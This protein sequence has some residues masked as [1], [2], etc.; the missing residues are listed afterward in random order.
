AAS[1][2]PRR[3]RTE[4]A[5]WRTARS[6]SAA[7]ESGVWG[8]SGARASAGKYRSRSSRRRT[9]R[10]VLTA[11][12]S[13]GF[14][15]Q[16][17]LLGGVQDDRLALLEDDLLGD[18]HLASGLLGR[19]VVHH[20]QHRGLEDGAETAGAGLAPDGLGGDGLQRAVGELQRHT[21][22]VE[23]LPVLLH[24][25]V[26]RLAED[27]HQRTLV[28]LLQRGD[29]GEPADELGDHPELE[30]VLGLDVLEQL[31]EVP[32]L[33]LLDV[34]PEAEGAATEPALDDLVQPSEGAAADEEDVGGVDLQE[35]L[36]RVLAS[37]LGRDVRD[38]ALDDLE[39]RLLHALARDVTGDA[40][41]LG[42]ARDLVDLVDVDDAP[43]SALDVV[44]GGLEQVDDDVL[45]VLAHV[46]GLGEAGGVGD[47]E[48]DVEDAGQG[49]GEQRLAAPGGAE[50]KDVA[51]LQLHV[52]HR[53][54]GLDA[55]VVVV[56][57][58][59]EDLLR[60]LLPDDVLVEDRLDLARAGDAELGVLGLLPVDLLGDDVVAET[61]ALVADVDRGPSDELL[62]L[63]LRL[64]AE[65]AAQ[66]LVG[67]LHVL[68]CHQSPRL[69]NLVL[70][71][72]F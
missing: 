54:L 7:A 1:A 33:L 2:A 36:L 52:V 65:G 23:E 12:R 29:D 32:L 48:R 63:L 5:S 57:R 47:G 41:V 14:L 53:D 18:H 20:V 72:R 50:Q 25:R 27:A 38:R 55:L 26:L 67:L 66:G 42:L 10:P 39:E 43:L 24:Q 62:H 71:C 22:E 40:R 68:P 46:A 58:D 16:L 6:A 28:E 21:V 64:S 35:L 49:L 3:S 9:A 11:E 37:A 51:L 69:P 44:V 70:V 59:R 19:D 61:D 30:Q 45:D 15:L 56:D 13:G 17:V 8:D 34:R 4:G 60:P 31:G